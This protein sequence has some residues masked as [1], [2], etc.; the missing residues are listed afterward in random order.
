VNIALIGAG[1]IGHV[2]A[3]NLHA[4]HRVNLVAIIEPDTRGEELAKRYN[5]KYFKS[6]TEALAFEK[7]NGALFSAVMICTPTHTHTDIIKEALIG[8]KNVLCEKPIGHDVQ[9]CDAV[10][11]LAKERNKWMLTAFHR[12]FDPAFSK[13]R[14]AVRSGACGKLHK[15]KSISRDNPVPSLEYLRHSGG[16]I[17]DCCS[18]DL[19]LIRWVIGVNPIKVFTAATT[20]DPEIKA[21]NDWDC[22]EITLFFPDDVLG[23]VDVTRKAVYG[24]DQRLEAVG[25][26][27][28]VSSNNTPILPVIV[29]NVNGFS[30]TA[31]QYSFN[32]RYADAYRGEV[33][34]FVDLCLGVT[35]K[36]AFTAEDLHTISKIMEACVESGKTGKLVEID[37]S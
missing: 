2:H 6:L 10:M 29:G 7:T 30:H 33:E 5:A 19:D 24:Y 37:Y 4:N 22:V 20:H 26:K 12:R 18:H 8:D 13:A 32:T 17:H 35:D 27:G 31:T 25:D 16:I 21:L 28:I 9:T 11:A 15:I 14:E 23:T 34:H 3:P 36:I 1:R